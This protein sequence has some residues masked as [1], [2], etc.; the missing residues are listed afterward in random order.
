MSAVPRHSGLPLDKLKVTAAGA[1]VFVALTAQSPAPQTPAPTL[2]EIGRVRS[3]GVC[4]TVRDSVAPMVLGLMKSDELVGAGHRAF[5]KMAD[6][7]RTGSDNALQIDQLYLRRASLAMAHNL[8]VIDTLL[9][10]RKRFPN[11]PKTDDDRIAQLL[12]EQIAAVA[13]Q[14]RKTLDVMNGALDTDALGRMQ[15][16]FPAGLSATG[17]GS[18]PK[19]AVV[20]AARGPDANGDY[21]GAAGLDMPSG[22]PTFDPR[23]YVASKTLGRTVW[24]RLAGTLELQQH[25]IA[26]REQKLSPTVIAISVAC[27][28]ELASPAPAASP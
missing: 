18:L 17:P 9:A 21:I 27:R 12:G 13:G 5:L 15:N 25:L 23:S 24:D 2:P 1:L 3:R 26:A 8:A 10:D 20:N 11:T 6:D 4:A 16:E 7:Q 28:E 22:T 19:G 14:Q